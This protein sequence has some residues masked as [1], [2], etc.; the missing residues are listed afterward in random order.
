VT[1]HMLQHRL[2][3]VDHRLNLPGARSI[4]CADALRTPDRPMSRLANLQAGQLTVEPIRFQ[5]PQLPAGDDIERYFAAARERRWF[6]NRGPCHRLLTD[7]LTE[8]LDA[9]LHVVLMANATLG[10]ML[11]LRTL[12]GHNPRGRFV[13]TP[14]FTFPATAQAIMWSGLEPLWVDVEP[15]GWHLDPQELSSALGAHRGNVAAVL[16][17]STFGTAPPVEHSAAW[18]HAC[19]EAE[20][21]LIVDSAPGFGSRDEHGDLL[22]AQGD[23]EI[24]SFHATKPF[25][26]GEG[27]MVTT[28]N[29]IVAKRL[30]EM[31]NFGFGPDREISSPF[32]LNAKMS[33]MHAAI[34]LAA[35]DDFEQVLT[36]R[37][38]LAERILS[39]LEHSGYS[40][41]A[42]CQGSTWQ[43]VPVMAPSADVRDAVLTR[44]RTQQIEIRNYHSPLHRMSV[45]ASHLAHGDLPV[46]DDLARRSLSL[47]LANDLAESAIQRIVALLGDCSP[48]PVEM[49][50]DRA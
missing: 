2:M 26:I 10:L 20:V 34:G 45:F 48:S 7:R 39:D 18:R 25:A 28:R 38:D 11:A 35:L 41:Q 4:T 31:A 8:F 49:Q 12:L 24:F 42:G 6:S 30:V 40:F 47:P 9:D 23:A 29:P 46:T 33:E 5:R 43:F 21:P 1:C 13:I 22:G 37:R 32:G 50:E 3:G 17:C 15:S 44:S 16:A 14:S 36:S 19:D 27:G